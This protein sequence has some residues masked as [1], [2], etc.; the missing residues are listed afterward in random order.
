MDNLNLTTPKTKFVVNTISYVQPYEFSSDSSDEDVSE[1]EYEEIKIKYH[2]YT[3]K[4]KKKKYN[5]VD[6]NVPSCDE[7]T[8][9]PAS[10]SN[11]AQDLLT[12]FSNKAFV[13]GDKDKISD[14]GL[15]IGLN[16]MKSVSTRRNKS[17]S[18][19]ASCEVDTKIRYDIVPFYW[20]CPWYDNEDSVVDAAEVTTVYK[21]LKRMDKLNL[22]NE[23]T[24]EKFLEKES[25]FERDCKNI[26]YQH[27]R[28]YIKNHEKTKL[29]IQEFRDKDANVN[30]YL[31]LIDDDVVDFNG[32]YSGYFDIVQDCVRAPTV[33][34]TGYEYPEDQVSGHAYEVFSKRNRMLRVV[35]ALHLPQGT[36]YPEPNMCVLLQPGEDTVKESFIDAER[37]NGNRLE[38]PILIGRIIE[39]RPDA[40]FIF[41][42]DRPIIIQIPL[43]A[44]MYH[45]SQMV[46]SDGLKYSKRPNEIDVKLFDQISQSNSRPY[47]WHKNLFINKSIEYSTD[48]PYDE[49]CYS[50]ENP[51][52]SVHQ[53]CIKIL[54]RLYRSDSDQERERLKNILKMRLRNKEIAD[55]MVRVFEERKKYN[56]YF[57]KVNVTNEES[58]DVD[59]IESLRKFYSPSPLMKF[60]FTFFATIVLRLIEDKPKSRSESETFDMDFEIQKDLMCV[61]ENFDDFN[62]PS[63]KRN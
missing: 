34:S 54:F 51:G 63:E 4:R 16:R 10:L 7:S 19:Q 5:V 23:E 13:E 36:Y 44:R 62:S 39:N 35:T 28:E 60:A 1:S 14:T 21:K 41:S 56:E 48:F 59:Y 46:F 47:V 6:C 40:T 11:Q 31:S 22:G 3:S 33:M 26:P 2:S 30:I 25:S 18:M 24:A 42:G 15:I 9:R 12:K 43:R 53:Q 38:S 32:I 49:F 57:S 52:K 37:G 55:Q 50:E 17:L 45:N 20:K 58:E 29:I 8:K 61:G 27:L